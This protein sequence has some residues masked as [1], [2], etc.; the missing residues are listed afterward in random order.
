[1]ASPR[2]K[3]ILLIASA[4]IL[5]AC[6]RSDSVLPSL[7]PQT[8]RFMTTGYGGPPA[9]G[10]TYFE[11]DGVTPGR[12][13]QTF[14]GNK[15]VSYR[16]EL[17][18][19]QDAI[20][21][22][23]TQLQALRNKTI[24]DSQGYHENVAAMRAK[25]QLGTTPANPSLMNRWEIAQAQLN[26]LNQDLVL[27]DQLSQVIVVN[28]S[29]AS[30]LLNTIRQSYSIPG[31]VD[32]DHR[33]LRILED[34]TQQ[35]V[36]LIERLLAELRSDVTRQT[37]YVN[38][39]RANLTSLASAIQQG[40]LFGVTGPDGYAYPAPANVR[41]GPGMRPGMPGRPGGPQGSQGPWATSGASYTSG[42]AGTNY[43]SPAPY[44][45]AAPAAMGVP[46]VTVRFDRAN[47]RYEDALTRAVQDTL[48]RNPSAS[49]SVVAVQSGT[50]GTAVRAADNALRTLT[51][52]GVPASRVSLS[53]ISQQG[54]VDELRVYGR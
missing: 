35:T 11:P 29:S 25:L 6:S 15:V 50:A 46:L 9:L 7:S 41:Q 52:L 17:S 38:S 3:H 5:A 21:T 49:F 39:E 37:A 20:R 12:P 45:A 40:Q 22:Q 8:E 36:V 13:T 19:M 32:E 27:M 2:T 10:N 26:T 18:G 16:A 48:S 43:A 47:I 34:E 23:N 54:G 30:Y 4:V 42:P 51:R 1:M 44:A 33:Q 53:S 28:Q 14:V 24:L 31:A